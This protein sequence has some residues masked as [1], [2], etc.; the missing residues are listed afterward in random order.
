MKKK[1]FSLF[2]LLAVFGLIFAGT[3][4][5]AEDLYKDVNFT[6]QVIMKGMKEAGYGLDQIM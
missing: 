4:M 6:M 3:N 5:Y 1:W 2:F